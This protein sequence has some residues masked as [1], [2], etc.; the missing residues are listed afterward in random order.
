MLVFVFEVKHTG[1]R[2]QEFSYSKTAF[3]FPNPKRKRYGNIIGVMSTLSYRD[4]HFPAIFFQNLGKPRP[5]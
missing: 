4:F 3:V 5:S 1:I 2:E